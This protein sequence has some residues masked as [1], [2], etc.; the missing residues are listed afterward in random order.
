MAANI[1][2]ANLMYINRT[3]RSILHLYYVTHRSASQII[4]SLPTQRCLA[5]WTFDGIV[6]RL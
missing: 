5:F 1:S 6:V 3:W 2:A 4:V